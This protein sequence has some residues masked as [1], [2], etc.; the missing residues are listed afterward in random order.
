MGRYV[1]QLVAF[2]EMQD[3]ISF[4]GEHQLAPYARVYIVAD[5]GGADLFAVIV[6]RFATRKAAADAIAQLPASLKATDPWPRTL[7][8]LRLIGIPQ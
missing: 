8:G 5:A 1:I 6:G 7:Q 3:A 4:I 2:R